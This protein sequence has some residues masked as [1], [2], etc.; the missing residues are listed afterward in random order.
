MIQVADSQDCM[1]RSVESLPG[2]ASGY[3]PAQR[4]Q[5]V[6]ISYPKS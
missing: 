5:F 3:I 1:Y 4:Y 2:G 6:A